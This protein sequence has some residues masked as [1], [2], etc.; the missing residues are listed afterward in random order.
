MTVGKF[1]TIRDPY[2][3]VNVCPI[4][5]AKGIYCVTGDLQ[6]RALFQRTLT[7]VTEV[8]FIISGSLTKKLQL[9]DFKDLA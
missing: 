7:T 6:F 3:T 5:T 8:Q 9:K 4:T 2:S 1:K